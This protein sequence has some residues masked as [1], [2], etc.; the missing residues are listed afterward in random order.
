LYAPHLLYSSEADYKEPEVVDKLELE[1]VDEADLEPPV[2]VE[3]DII[4]EPIQKLLMSQ[5]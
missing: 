2:L 3:P 5:N 1:A 4:D